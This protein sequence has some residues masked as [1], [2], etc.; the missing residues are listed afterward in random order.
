MDGEIELGKQSK[1]ALLGSLTMFRLLVK[2]QISMLRRAASVKK[3][4]EVPGPFSYLG[5]LD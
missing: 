1:G 5:K 4:Q 3:G 2:F